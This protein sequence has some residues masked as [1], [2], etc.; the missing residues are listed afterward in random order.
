[1]A[2]A[3]VV[4]AVVAADVVTVVFCVVS[5]FLND[6]LYGSLNYLLY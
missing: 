1:M 2:T 5:V 6:S 3:V 4:A